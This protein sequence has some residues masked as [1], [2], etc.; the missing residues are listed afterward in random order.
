MPE[1]ED[2]TNPVHRARLTKRPIGRILVDAGFVTEQTLQRALA[3]QANTGEPVGEILVSLGLLD[4]A[5]LKAVL[6]IQGDLATLEDALKAASGEPQRLGEL[7]VRAGRATPEEIGSAL[8]EQKK[9]NERLGGI[10]VR[11]GLVNEKELETVLA[12]QACQTG[13]DK[14]GKCRL[15]E[16][17]LTADYIT[18]E[19]LD[20]ALRLQE[21]SDGVR[22]GSI[23]VAAGHVQPYHVEHALHIQHKLATAALVAALTLAVAPQFEPG[24]AVAA[25]PQTARVSVGAVVKEYVSAKVVLQTRE[26]VVTHADAAAGFVDVPLATVMEV[27][28]NSQSGYLVAF[29]GLGGPFTGIY[30]RGFQ[31]EAQITHDGGWVIQ[32]GPVRG[33]QTLQLSYRFVLASGAL[34]GTY[35]WPL[36]I[37]V[38]PL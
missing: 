32:S 6:A 38:H 34:P 37:T 25:P 10:L 11:R 26:L 28:S 19:Q 1:I 2:K 30:V 23:L 35:A 22:L 36:V 18:R 33:A 7:V 16:L 13:V 21:S 15:G 8:E 17:L 29:N 9:T 5:A 3:R 4:E 24:S 31:S 20:N 14:T 12:F 27:K